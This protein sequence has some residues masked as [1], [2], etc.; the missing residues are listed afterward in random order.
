MSKDEKTSPL[1][2]TP[3]RS[4]P[5]ISMQSQS[6]TAS[7]DFAISVK[8]CPCCGQ[9]LTVTLGC[10]PPTMLQAL[11]QAAGHPPLTSSEA[12]QIYRTSLKN[13]VVSL[14]RIEGR[15]LPTSTSRKR[16]LAFWAFFALFSLI[17]ATILTLV[18]LA[19]YTPLLAD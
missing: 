13:S 9:K 16:S 5:Y 4:S 3:W 8:K 15:S 17:S 18:S 1:T 11:R 7:S 10:E 2:G 12:E 14:S 6:A 19:I